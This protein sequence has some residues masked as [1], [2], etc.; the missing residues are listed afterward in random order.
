MPLLRIQHRFIVGAVTA[1]PAAA[2]PAHAL[3][4]RRPHPLTVFV[5]TPSRMDAPTARRTMRLLPIQAHIIC[6]VATAR[7]AAAIPVH[8]R[9]PFRH[10]Q[11]AV[12]RDTPLADRRLSMAFAVLPTVEPYALPP[13]HRVAVQAHLL[14]SW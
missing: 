8:A 2:I 7:M 9:W 10:A 13:L 4:P 11:H 1:F 14:T 3:L 5:I 6:G 12:A